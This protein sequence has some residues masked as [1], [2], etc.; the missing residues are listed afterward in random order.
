MS[1]TTIYSMSEPQELT[2][3]LC[4]AVNTE[5]DATAPATRQPRARPCSVSAFVSHGLWT[6]CET[7]A[8]T[9]EYFA[10]QCSYRA[11][12]TFALPPP[13]WHMRPSS[14]RNPLFPCANFDLGPWR[15]AL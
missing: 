14:L 1:G 11:P 9:Q 13:W 8:R 12:E 3:R 2:G 15:D 5:V 4:P 6:S 10:E 7:C